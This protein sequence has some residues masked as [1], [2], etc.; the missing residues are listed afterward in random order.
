MIGLLA[1]EV[2]DAKVTYSVEC[3]GD[4]ASRDRGN[5]E[6]FNELES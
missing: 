6:L 4:K 1:N 5:A 2:P 3:G